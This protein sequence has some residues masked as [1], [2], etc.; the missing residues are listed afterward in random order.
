MNSQIARAFVLSRLHDGQLRQLHVIERNIGYCLP[1]G[2]IH[3][4]FHTVE[5]GDIT[6]EAQNYAARP[7]MAIY[8]RIRGQHIARAKAGAEITEMAM[9]HEVDLEIRRTGVKFES[10]HS[11]G[12]SLKSRVLGGKRAAAEAEVFAEESR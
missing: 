6:P 4:R 12:G 9:T 1:A 3:D 10:G 7:V 5:W 8:E 2:A 11:S